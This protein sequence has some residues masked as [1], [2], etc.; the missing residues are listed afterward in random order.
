MRQRCNKKADPG[1][2]ASPFGTTKKKLM[3]LNQIGK[4]CW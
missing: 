1:G 3:S 2:S 4:L